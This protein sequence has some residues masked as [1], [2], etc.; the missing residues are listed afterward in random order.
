M[1]EIEAYYKEHPQIKPRLGSDWQ[2]YG[3]LLICHWV[4]VVVM[5]ALVIVIKVTGILPGPE[6]FAA[7]YDTS[8]PSMIGQIAFDWTL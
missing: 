5:V 7:D 8:L 1:E 4:T 2:V 6:K 3:R